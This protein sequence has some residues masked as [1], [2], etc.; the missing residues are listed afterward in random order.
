MIGGA[1]CPNFRMPLLKRLKIGRE[2]RP[3]FNIL[4]LR[5]TLFPPLIH[6]PL[7]FVIAD[8]AAS[9]GILETAIDNA[10]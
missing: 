9:F 6:L 10:G 8:C 1:V 5:S 4:L 3:G 7:Q 2:I